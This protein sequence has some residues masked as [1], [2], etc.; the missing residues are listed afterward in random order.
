MLDVLLNLRGRPHV[1]LAIR[2][3]LML[4]VITLARC[5]GR[6]STGD[7]IYLSAHSSRMLGST[8]S[9]GDDRLMTLQ[10]MTVNVSSGAMNGDGSREALPRSV[11]LR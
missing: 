4:M 5:D 3:M 10:C 2:A 6:W 8:E 11:P 9:G 7:M 1:V